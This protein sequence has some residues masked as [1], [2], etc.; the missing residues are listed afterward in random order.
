[1]LSPTLCSICLEYNSNEDLCNIK[2]KKMCLIPAAA[3]ELD[4]CWVRCW[5]S[6]SKGI[7]IPR[8]CSFPPSVVTCRNWALKLL[9]LFDLW[10]TLNLFI[11]IQERKNN[12]ALHGVVP[13]CVLLPARSKTRSLLQVIAFHLLFFFLHRYQT[14]QHVGLRRRLTGNGN[15][16]VIF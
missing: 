8:E 5:S 2:L 11:K 3:E 14:H 1:M 15:E 4:R 10:P 13:A 6:S 12:I 9:L 16:N 7:H